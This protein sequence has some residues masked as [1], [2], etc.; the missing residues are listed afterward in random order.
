MYRLAVH[1]ALSFRSIAHIGVPAFVFPQ[2]VR[3][4]LVSTASHLLGFLGLLL[5][6]LF[7]LKK[8]SAVDMGQDTT[9]GDGGANERIEFLVTADRQL[10]MAGGDALDLEILGGILRRKIASAYVPRR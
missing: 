10:Q 5:P 2:K 9:K 6:L 7:N 4:R 8:Q 1:G 3:N